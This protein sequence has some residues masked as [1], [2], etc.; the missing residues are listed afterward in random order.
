M[1]SSLHE[2]IPDRVVGIREKLQLDAGASTG[3]VKKAYMQVGG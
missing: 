3:Q 2:L 1:L